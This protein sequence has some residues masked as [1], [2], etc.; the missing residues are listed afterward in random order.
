V[1][2]ETNRYNNIT[3]YTLEPSAGRL[4]DKPLDVTITLDARLL[5]E[6]QG[7]QY[8]NFFTNDPDNAYVSIPFNY[9]ILPNEDNGSG[10]IQKEE[11][12]GV[13]GKTVASI[14]V[15]TPP[16]LVTDITELAGPYGHG[17]NYGVRIRGYIQAPQT[18]Y[19][20]FYIASDD[21]SELWLSTN[22]EEENKVKIAY[23]NSFVNPGQFTAYPSQQS[24]PVYL[25]GNNKYYIEV[26]HKEGTGRDHLTVAWETPIG[27]SEMP[28]PGYRLFPLNF[29]E[30]QN[31]KPTVSIISP[32]DGQT[33]Q[34][35]TSIE[36][37]AEA[38]DSDGN[39]IKVE[40]YNGIKKLGVDFSAPYTLNWNH[41]TDGTYQLTAKAFDNHGATDSASVNITLHGQGACSGGGII[42]REVWTDVAGD[43]VSFIPVNSPPSHISDLT[44]FESP[45][46]Y[47][48]SF[49]SRIRGYLCVPETGDYTFWIASDD[50]SELWLS[51]NESP[52][53]KVKIASVNG[54]TR[55]RQ[56]DK[57]PSQKSAAIRLSA[58]TRYYIEALHK[59]AAGTDHLAVGWQLPNGTL[60]R[61]IAGNRL[62][63]FSAV[64][65]PSVSITSPVNGQQFDGPASIIIQADANDNDGTI[66]RVEFYQDNIKLGEDTTIPYSFTWN[67][68]APGNYSL[69]AKAFD[70]GGNSA[71]SFSVDIVVNYACAGTGSILWEFWVN[72]PGTS[73]EDI[74]VNDNP[75]MV[76]EFDIFE[77]PSYF[78]NNYGARL[79]GYICVPQTGAYT[80]WIASDD[81]GELWLST[82]TDLANKVKIASVPGHTN[83]RQWDKYPSQKSVTINLEAGH[84]YYVEALHKEATG[85][86][87]IAVGWQLPDG[88]LERP[89]PGN[90]LTP[91]DDGS[92]T[93]AARLAQDTRS[94]IYGDQ[95]VEQ[96]ISL[97]P[98]PASQGTVT[99]SISDNDISAIDEASV[100][101]INSTGITVYTDIS[102]C[103]GGHCNLSIEA[104]SR[105]IPGVYIVNALIN[106]KRYSKRLIIY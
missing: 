91:Y 27:H 34:A 51:T 74:P 23:L 17:D 57:Y 33:F 85:N 36:I 84:Q 79:S 53:N 19:Y 42:Q 4:D 56:W 61:P 40:F 77:S 99:L 65:A 46:N 101:I 72:A 81:N 9:L 78:A 13:T 71:T 89:I 90:R 6:G 7:W 103:E 24:E 70:Y 96:E 95:E 50:H 35:P 55:R 54:H 62:I 41:V 87:H 43:R 92:G 68:V 48:D 15:D 14:P 94:A 102:R 76:S 32:G 38:F 52:S 12:S 47:G 58:G 93:A 80:F 104:N 63:P 69:V 30:P 86:D 20:T 98:N 106:R 3:L 100:E 44:I 45:Y 18:G 82:D 39:I 2:F 73:V 64:S 8:I 88:T 75:A 67:N 83:S 28:I 29:N 16:S 105:F 26:L 37:K 11:W 59:E 22:M 1:S 60:E 21:H 66:A 31:Q 10:K 5:E 97:F 25:Q 49:G